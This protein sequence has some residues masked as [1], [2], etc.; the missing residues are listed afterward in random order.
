MKKSLGKFVLLAGI[1]SAGI[2]GSQVAQAEYGKDVKNCREK[3]SQECGCRHRHHDGD[4]GSHSR[5]GK[6]RQHGFW[7]L[8]KSLGLSDV[9]RN[10]VKDIFEKNRAESQP[11]RM[12]L[13]SAKRELRGL[14]MAEKTDEAAIRTQ[15]AKLAGIETDMTIRR[16]KLAGQIRAILTPE[17]LEKFRAFQ[18]EQSQKF[19]DRKGQS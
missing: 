5:N 18:R 2:M 11:L 6:D 9:Q 14:A 10:Q 4:N 3:I 15:A 19:N 7:K 12:E 8:A 17:Q 1:A 16:A 13:I